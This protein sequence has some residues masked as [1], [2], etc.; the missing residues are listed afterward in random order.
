MSIETIY[1]TVTAIRYFKQGSLWRVFLFDTGRG[2]PIKAVGST[3]PIEVGDYLKLTG[4]FEKNER[5]GD[6]FTIV[7]AEKSEPTRKNAVYNYLAGGAL[8]GVGEATAKLLIE[9]FGEEALFIIEHEPHRLIEISG[10]G[11]KRSSAIHEAYMEQRDEVDRHIELQQLGLMPLQIVKVKEKYGDDCVKLIYENPYRL[12][13]DFE[14]IGF[15]TAD[16]IAQKAGVEHDSR[17]RIMAY[18]GFLL[19]EARGQGSTYIPMEQLIN[20]AAKGLCVD[21]QLTEYALESMIAAGEL[22]ACMLDEKYVVFLPYL[23]ACEKNCANRLALLVGD[24]RLPFNIDIDQEID[25]LEEHF[26]ITLAEKQRIAV[27][28][29]LTQ[30]VLVITGGPG[31][32]KTTILRFI[33]GIMQRLSLDFELCAPTGRAAKRMSEATGISARTIHRML[34]SNGK[35]FGRNTENPLFTDMIIVDEMSMVDISLFSALLKALTPETR[36]IMVGDSDQLPSVGPGN[37]LSDIIEC[38]RI[39]LI[40]LNEIFRQS[41]QS[42][43]IVNAH[44]I[45]RGEHPELTSKDREFCFEPMDSVEAVCRRICSLCTDEK[46]AALFDCGQDE[47]QVLTPMKDGILGVNELNICLQRAMNPRDPYKHEREYGENTIFREG[48]KVMQT[49]N[50]YG[51]Q[52]K[53]V[54]DGVMV[55]EGAGVFNGDLG[56]ILTIDRLG[57]YVLVRFDDGREAMYSYSQLEELTHAFSITIHK[58]QG[59]EFPAVILPLV[60]VAPRLTTRNLIYTAI[61][62]AK[63]Q[64][65]IIGKRECVYAM[66][67]TLDSH[68]RYSALSFFLDECMMLTGERSFKY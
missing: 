42:S 17:Q 46:Y 52:W 6:Q 8:R 5:H 14:G 22:N 40:R 44:I 51:M 38:D 26:K 37:V 25:L 68:K 54:Q 13:S 23:Y 35:E 19:G 50:N 16:K 64:V 41:G 20:G 47:I 28:M 18:I 63:K 45:N 57:Q 56:T 67:D 48:D 31:T 33:I 53:L 61:T 62:R 55:D 60:H 39:P 1:G 10:I 9:H 65:Y 4:E 59:S 58:S 3:P 66:I 49:K 21:V 29:A 11:D 34:E 30:G 2:R 7:H 32:G 36:L 24:R 15:I 12:I 43:I 27:K